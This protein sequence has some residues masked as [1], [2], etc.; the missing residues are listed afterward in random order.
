MDAS[1]LPQDTG[2]VSQQ[3]T[4]LLRMSSVPRLR[5]AGIIGKK[6]KNL[7][8]DRLIPPLLNARREYGLLSQSLLV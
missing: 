5:N 2:K 7:L 1:T 3:R 8:Q 4:I 6:C